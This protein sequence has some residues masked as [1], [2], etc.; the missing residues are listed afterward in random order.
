MTAGPGQLTLHVERDVPAPRLIVFTN[1]VEPHE[2]ARWWGPNGFTT[3]GVELDARVGG[4]YRITMQPPDGHPFVLAG[5]FREVDRPARLVYTFRYDDPDPDD[6]ETVVEVA[7]D[8][9]GESTNVVVDQG[10]FATEARLALHD[11]GWTES[12]ERLYEVLTSEHPHP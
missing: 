8:D 4:R 1:F 9:L 10:V 3:R 6:R 2:L 11:Q 5:E 7:L 12:L